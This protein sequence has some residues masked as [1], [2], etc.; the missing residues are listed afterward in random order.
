M[1]YLLQLAELLRLLPLFKF[2][3]NLLQIHLSHFE[4]LGIYNT[5]PLCTKIYINKQ[6]STYFH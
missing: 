4:C 3:T 2:S 6:L 1:A 5:Q